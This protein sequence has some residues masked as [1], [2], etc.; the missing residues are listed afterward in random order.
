MRCV[1]DTGWRF[2]SANDSTMNPDLFCANTLYKP[3]IPLTAMIPLSPIFRVEYYDTKVTT[4]FPWA[5]L[6]SQKKPVEWSTGSLE[7][8]LIRLFFDKLGSG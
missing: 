3:G 8:L 1:A 2:L 4:K 5:D 6:N 7:I